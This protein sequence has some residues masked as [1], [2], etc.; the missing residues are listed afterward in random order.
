MRNT[1]N[2]IGLTALLGAAALLPNLACAT[3]GGPEASAAGDSSSLQGS[4]KSTLRSTYRVHEILLPSGTVLREYAVAGGT[5]FAVVWEGPNIPDLRQTLGQYFDTYVVEQA[6]S[7]SRTQ[8]AIRH[9][10][11]VAHVSGHMRA[12]KGTAY[13]PQAVP[14]GVNVEDL[15]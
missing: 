9:E 4:I 11:F 6:R 5:V 8:L 7:A 12:F 1:L 2:L 15:R 13:L 3:L 14:A 10:D